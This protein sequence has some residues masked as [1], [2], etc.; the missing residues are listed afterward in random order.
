MGDL[1]PEELEEIG[2]DPAADPP[3][4]WTR[5]EYEDRLLLRGITDRHS[6]PSMVRLGVQAYLTLLEEH[7]LLEKRPNISEVTDVLTMSAPDS[8]NTVDLFG[9]R[10]RNLLPGQRVAAHDA[11][12]RE[13]TR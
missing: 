1:A 13:A 8:L 4:S 6:A 3:S 5:E 11:L 9:S 2:P 12:G 10:S 7:G